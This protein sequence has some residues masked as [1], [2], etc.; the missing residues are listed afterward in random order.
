MGKLQTDGRSSTVSL[1]MQRGLLH[2]LGTLQHQIEQSRRQ[3][4]P[5]FRSF[6]GCLPSSP[7]QAPMCFSSGVVGHSV[8]ATPGL[9][10]LSVLMTI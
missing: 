8:A 6:V 1:R 7:L 4:T 10:R 5:G 3:H 2:G 9:G